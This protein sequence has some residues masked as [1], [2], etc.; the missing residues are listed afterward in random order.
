MRLQVVAEA[1]RCPECGGLLLEESA[2]TVCASCGFVISTT[3]DLGPESPGYTPEQA[4]PR[5][6]TGPPTSQRMHES[7][8]T[9]IGYPRSGKRSEESDAS[10]RVYSLRKWQAKSRIADSPE[11]TLANGL[12]EICT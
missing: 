2:E 5:A 4:A 11:R 10:L 12:R 6:R 3:F 1:E 8:T 9:V 7:L